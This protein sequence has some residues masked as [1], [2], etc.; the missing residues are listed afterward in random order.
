MLVFDLTKK[1][2]EEALAYNFSDFEQEYIDNFKVK[3]Y[4]IINNIV[5]SNILLSFK[6]TD[7]K[8]KLNT[9]VDRLK[10]TMIIV[11]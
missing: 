10:N 4:K 1:D 8:E 7:F 11:S 3:E 2:I 5:L 6:E 9:G